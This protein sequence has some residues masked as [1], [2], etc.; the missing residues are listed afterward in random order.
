[1]KAI[2]F[3]LLFFT[4]AISHAKDYTSWLENCAQYREAVE[5]ILEKENVSKEYYYLMVAESRCRTKAESHK[6]AR[7]FWQLM[8][9]TGKHYGCSDL[10]NIECSTRAAILYIKHLQSS[11]RTFKEVI[12]AY[13]M[14]GHNYRR[15]GATN[16]AKGLYKRVM[17]I[18]R[19]DNQ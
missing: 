11:F 8:P 12:F 16:E 7:G 4:C 3:V 18:K 19:D 2:A 10:D 9:R 17:E 1:M 6:G 15:K 13:N 14:G 5:S